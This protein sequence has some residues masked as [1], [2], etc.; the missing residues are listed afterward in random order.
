LN[1]QITNV[2]ILSELG[3]RGWTELDTKLDGLARSFENTERSQIQAILET[4]ST[5]TKED[6]EFS[7]IKVVNYIRRQSTRSPPRIHGNTR[8][9]ITLLEKIKNSSCPVEEKLEFTRRLIG[10]LAWKYE[11]MKGG[12]W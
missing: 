4:I 7:I 11:Y 1:D 5:S 9:L 8:E 6:F 3:F 2:A 12:R 10:L